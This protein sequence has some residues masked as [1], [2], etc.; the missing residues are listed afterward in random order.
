[1][2]SA[3]SVPADFTQPARDTNESTEASHRAFSLPALRKSTSEEQLY[4]KRVTVALGILYAVSLLFTKISVLFLYRR[5]FTMN[6]RW[7]RNST[8]KQ[9][10]HELA[11]GRRVELRIR[12]SSSEYARKNGYKAQDAFEG[13]AGNIVVTVHGIRLHLS[14]LCLLYDCQ[15]S[16]QKSQ[17]SVDHKCYKSPISAFGQ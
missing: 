3:H 1:M 5:I 14:D 10:T 7:F 4:L 16:D 13:K 9:A 8:G 11:I 17:R 2:G 12:P 15:A 6:T